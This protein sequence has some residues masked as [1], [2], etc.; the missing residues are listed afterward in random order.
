[1]VEIDYFIKAELQK[2]HF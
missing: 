2:D 1:M